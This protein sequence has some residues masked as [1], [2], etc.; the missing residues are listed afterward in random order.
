MPQQLPSTP[1]GAALSLLRASVSAL[2]A[3]SLLS[4]AY[5]HSKQPLIRRLNL[6]TDI[7][8]VSLI[9]HSTRRS[10]QFCGRCR[11]HTQSFSIGQPLQLP[12]RSAQC[13]VWT[14]LCCPYFAQSAHL[15]RSDRPCCTSS[16]CACY[17]ASCC[18]S[19]FWGYGM[20]TQHSIQATVLQSQVALHAH[21]ETT[22]IGS[23]QFAAQILSVSCD[24]CHVYHSEYRAL[25]RR[26][27]DLTQ[28]RR[29]ELL[30]LIMELYASSHVHVSVRI[31]VNM[32]PAV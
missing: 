12:A 11:L 31:E 13:A 2:L 22:G 30:S 27:N 5:E 10:R 21:E 20:P 3:S 18:Y 23:C 4:L 7:L 32:H 1:R 17:S 19:F 8:C 24:I 25:T 15:T 26:A 6:L 14:C 29:F 16:L 28:Y 9:R